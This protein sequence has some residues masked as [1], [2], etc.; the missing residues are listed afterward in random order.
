[1][2]ALT[3]IHLYVNG[4]IFPTD[5]MCSS[6]VKPRISCLARRHSS[7]D[8]LAYELILLGMFVFLVLVFARLQ[9]AGVQFIILRRSIWRY[10][11]S[12]YKSCGWWRLFMSPPYPTPLA[13]IIVGTIVSM[14]TLQVVSHVVCKVILYTAPGSLSM[15]VYTPPVVSHVVW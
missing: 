6:R 3:W 11:Y 15:A 8:A 4:Y 14:C 13:S 9:W 12:V 7:L 10:A 5:R 2:M 1:M